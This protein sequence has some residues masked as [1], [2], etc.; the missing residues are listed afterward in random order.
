MRIGIFWTAML[1]AATAP[2]WAA[3]AKANGGM[4]PKEI[5]A[6]LGTLPAVEMPVF[7]QERALAMVAMPLACVDHPQ[8]LPEQRVEYLWVHEDK[9]RI[10]EGYTANRAFYGCS[11]WHSAVNSTWTLI[12][13]LKKFP[14]IAV[15]PLIREK[16]KDHLGKKNIEGEMAFFKEA[17]NFE[18]PYGYAWLLKVYAELVTWNDPDANTW[19]QN[20][21]PMVEQFSKKV[22]EYLTDLKLPVRQGMHPNTA[23][24][25]HLMLDY[26]SVVNDVT[27]KE[28][29]LK[30]ANRFFV[31]DRTC[32]TAYEPAG[33][34]FLSPCLAEAQLMTAVLDKSHF[35]TWFNDF[36]PAVYSEAFKPLTVPVDVSTMT[37][38]DLQGGKSHLVGLGFSRGQALLEIAAALPADDPRVP[39]FRR[40]AAMDGKGAYDAL[41]EVGYEGSHW[42]ATYAVLFSRAAEKGSP[43]GAASATRAPAARQ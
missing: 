1:C 4:D 33:S 35:L 12:A 24:T 22:Q 39:V 11:D 10:L 38:K 5:T 26:T 13:V 8:A 20:L 3:D 17:R 40:V 37:K 9:P 23:F 25:S 31:N 42:F 32:P 6:Y 16:L 41:A 19:A 28:A 21:A 27:L 15:G 7:D 18:L 29:L 30:T 34:D 2:A 43:A 14:K 36:F